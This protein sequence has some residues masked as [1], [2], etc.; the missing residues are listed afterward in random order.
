MELA[1]MRVGCLDAFGVSL[2]HK[3]IRDSELRRNV[4]DHRP[5]HIERASKKS[6]KDR[7]VP[8][9]TPNPIL[10]RS[11]LRLRINC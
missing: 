7:A 6:P 5:W 2:G 3:G 1:R 8:I 10:M 4:I 11:P 9:R